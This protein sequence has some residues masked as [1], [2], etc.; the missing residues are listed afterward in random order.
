MAPAEETAKQVSMIAVEYGFSQARITAK[1]GQRLEI[2]IT[3]KGTMNHE[4]ISALFKAAKDVEMK[5][6][7]FK[8]EA[9]EFEEV[10]FQPG[11]TVTIELTPTRAGT[12]QFWCGEK[13]NGKLHR[14]LGMRGTITV[15]R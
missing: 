5:P 2:R 3:N 14:D 11:K 7:G 9:E 6:E 15:T 10:E 12:F 1:V 13:T 8:I 4:F